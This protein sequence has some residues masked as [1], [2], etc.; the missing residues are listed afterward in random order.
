MQTLEKDKQTLLQELRRTHHGDTAEHLLRSF[1]ERFGNRLVLA[2]SLAVEDQVLTDMA[3]AIDPSVS[4]ITLDTGRL[5]RETHETIQATQ[6]YYD[7]DIRVLSPDPARVEAMVGRHGPDLFY[8]SVEKRKLCCQVRKIEPLRRALQEKEVWVCGLRREQS[9]TRTE[10]ERIQWDE[11]FG[12]IKLAPLLDWRI[13]AVWE[14]VRRHDVPYNVLHE[15]GYPSIGCAP[16]TR[17][18]RDGRDLRA[19]RWWWEPPEHKECG[20]H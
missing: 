12:L 16:C 2:S 15:R 11:Q 19:G 6:N 14:Y 7:I 9:V 1:M 20:L 18:V 13:D 5:P 10:L 17:A 4:I 3:V 8:E